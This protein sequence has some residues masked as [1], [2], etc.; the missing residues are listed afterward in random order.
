MARVP[1]LVQRK[2]GT[3]STRLD[4]KRK[5]AKGREE[6]R[7]MAD[8]Q[9]GWS[10]EDGSWEEAGKDRQRGRRLEDEEDEIGG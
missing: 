9:G 2:I 8:S 10:R 3:S 5:T 7:I 6:R 1:R 4:G